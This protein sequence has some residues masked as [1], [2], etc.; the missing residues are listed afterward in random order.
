[1]E[2]RFST[3]PGCSSLKLLNGNSM[4]T[5]IIREVSSH[6]VTRAGR[7]GE[8][9][10]DTITYIVIQPSYNCPEV[11]HLRADDDYLT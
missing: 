3:V 9:E 11:K 4:S 1:M 8:N 10:R 7:R 6:G 5:G 2:I